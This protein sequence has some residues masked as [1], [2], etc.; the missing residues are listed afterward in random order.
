MQPSGCGPVADRNQGVGFLD[1]TAALS[2]PADQTRPD[3]TDLVSTALTYPPGKL[4]ALRWWEI[5]PRVSS[6][7]STHLSLCFTSSQGTCGIFQR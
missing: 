1:P 3:Q 4:C 6:L 2:L 7:A 5:R